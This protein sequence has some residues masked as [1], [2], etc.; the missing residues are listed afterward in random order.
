M[1][2]HKTIEGETWDYIAKKYYGDERFM[3]ILLNA[4]P[5]YRNYLILPAYLEIIIP[6]LPKPVLIKE[7][8]PPWKR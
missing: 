5:K 2:I 6:E 1:R 4:N 7:E 8:L 3:D